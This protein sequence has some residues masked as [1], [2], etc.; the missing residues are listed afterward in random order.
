VS[1]HSACATRHTKLLEFDNVG[2]ALDLISFNI[3][4][5]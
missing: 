4:P 5:L 3:D 1:R 2:P